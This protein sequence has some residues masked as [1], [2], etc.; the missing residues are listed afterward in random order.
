M[1]RSDVQTAWRCSGVADL[2][3]P[4][5]RCWCTTRVLQG[6][7]CVWWRGEFCA[8]SFFVVTG[9]TVTLCPRKGQRSEPRHRPL[10]SGQQEGE[11]TGCRVQD[12]WLIL[13]RGEPQFVQ[14]S[15]KTVNES[16]MKT[17]PKKPTGPL[18]LVSLKIELRIDM[19]IGFLY[20]IYKRR[21]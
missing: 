20:A 1:F 2:M 12:C 10:N 9:F 16:S 11:L 21:G 6:L 5:R 19:F 13:D 7:V 15:R 3:C 14:P 4:T 17:K 18:V 8:F